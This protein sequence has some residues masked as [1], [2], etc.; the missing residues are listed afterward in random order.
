[1]ADVSGAEIVINVGTG[2]GVR[3]GG[4]YDVIRP[5][6]EIKDPATGQLVPQPCLHCSPG[7]AVANEDN[8]DKDDKPDKAD[9]TPMKRKKKCRLSEPETRHRR[10]ARP[11]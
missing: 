3:V 4:E 5:G 10:R 11:G 6:R 7:A 1:M 9:N 2:A 8:D